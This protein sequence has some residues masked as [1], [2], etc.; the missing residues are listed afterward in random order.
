[1]RNVLTIFGKEVGH[2]TGSA[3]SLVVAL[4]FAELS[5]AFFVSYLISTS[6]ADTSIRGFVNGARFLIPLFAVFLTMRLFAGER[7]SGT[8][9]LLMTAPLRDHEIALGKFLGS[10]AF[11][12]GLLAVT[13]CFP[14]LLAVFGDPD[15]GPIMTSYLALLLLGAT[16]LAIGGFAS[17]TTA[18]PLVA[19]AVATSIL[20]ALWLLGSAGRLVPGPLGAALVQLSPAAH[21]DSFFRG[22]IDSRDVIYH[23]SFTAGFLYLTTVAIA[24]ERVR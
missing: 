13:F 18:S 22:V 8:W 14:L 17:A 12:A 6:Y 9:E 3:A 24:L 11:L 23:L 21:L 10:L 4:L 1:M 15:I 20:L 7:R 2:H 5:A 16:C 19:A